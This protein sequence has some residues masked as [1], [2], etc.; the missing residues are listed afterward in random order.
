MKL[1]SQARIVDITENVEYKKFLYRCIVGPPSK[2]C[3]ER[4]KYLEEAIPRGFHKKL[5]LLNEQVVGQIEY[6]PAEAS[7]YPIIGDNVVVLNCVWVLRKA[8]GQG[9]GKRLLEDMM[10]SEKDASGFAIVALEGHWSPWFRKDQMEKLGFKSIDCMTVTHQVKHGQAFKIH[11]MWRP[12]A[13]NAK[14]P[15]WNEQKLLEGITSCTAHPLYHPRTYEPK[16]IFQEQR[17][18]KRVRTK[19]GC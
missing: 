6:S 4:M 12:N 16:K 19:S 9:F 2:Q 17:G 10:T 13:K 18:R 15:T 3:R 14:P 1:A 7:Y 8:G 11:L 5:L